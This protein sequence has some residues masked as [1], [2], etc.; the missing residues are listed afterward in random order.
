MIRRG[1]PQPERCVD[2]EWIRRRL[3]AMV[4]EAGDG[5]REVGVDTLIERVRFYRASSTLR[6]ARNGW[7]SRPERSVL[8]VEAMALLNSK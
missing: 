4:P 8:V 3:G 6:I 5:W 2:H 7:L 1:G